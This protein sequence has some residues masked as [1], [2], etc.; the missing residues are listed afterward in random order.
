MHCSLATVAALAMAGVLAGSGEEAEQHAPSA[1]G[2]IE[3]SVRFLGPV[4]QARI[5]DNAGR[6]RPILSVEDAE[7]GL[8]YAAVYLSGPEVEKASVADE[9][10]D[11]DAGAIPIIDQ[12]DLTFVPHLVAVRSGQRVAFI[13]SDPENHNVRAQAQTPR[14]RFNIMT[15]S[16]LDYERQFRAETNGKPVR[17]SCDIHPWMSAWVFAF[18]H[19]YFD[20]TGEHGD[21]SIEAVPAGTYSIVVYQPDGEL[22][23]EGEMTVAA[24][25]TIRLSVEFSG[26][27]L[28]G[29]RIL[30]IETPSVGPDGRTTVPD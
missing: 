14:N 1:Y 7:N 18:D 30:R 10:S 25:A 21:F 9:V 4:P 23:A 11:D 8:R 27:H 3:G 12:R 2:S 6:R 17:L 16:G 20:V 13:N 15:V 24:G 5:A 26:K 29:D 19:P 28:G 22:R